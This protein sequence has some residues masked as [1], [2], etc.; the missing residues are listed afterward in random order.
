AAALAGEKA[1]GR[2]VIHG[3]LCHR[4]FGIGCVHLQDRG[5]PSNRHGLGR[6]MRSAQPGVREFGDG[7][8][9]LL[10]SW[11]LPSSRGAEGKLVDSRRIAA[12]VRLG[13]GLV[14]F[15]YL[16]MHFANHA[17]GLGSLDALAWGRDW[18]LA[19][20]RNAVGTTVLYGAFALHMGLAFWSI[21]RR[22]SLRMPAS[23]ATQLVVGLLIPP[24][25]AIHV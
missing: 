5:P 15:A 18:F 13:S 25:L 20:W 3:R 19:V 10:S 8:R 9:P 12:R 22:R 23:E 7:R 11:P 17:L 4:H 2:G 14:L 16:V 1:L 6:A 21:Y 24:L